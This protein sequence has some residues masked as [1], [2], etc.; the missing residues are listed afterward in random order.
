MGL[1]DLTDRER[2]VLKCLERGLGT[3]QVAEELFIS[4]TTVRNHIQNIMMKLDA[5]TRLQAVAI[6]RGLTVTPPEPEP[7]PLD[8][9]AV[10]VLEFLLERRIEFTDAQATAI[11]KAFA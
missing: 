11:C 1:P 8:R 2:D 10:T 3:Q 9:R 5:R 6:A 7:V 4:S